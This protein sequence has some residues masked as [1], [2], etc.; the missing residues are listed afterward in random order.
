MIREIIQLLKA[1]D[2]YNVS[3]T[4]DI[5]KGMYKLPTNRKEIK[6]HRKRINGYK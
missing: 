5:A 1:D 6:E 4:I 2:Y 3:D